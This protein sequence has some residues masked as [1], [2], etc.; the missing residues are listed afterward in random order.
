MTRST[1]ILIARCMGLVA[2]FYGVSFGLA[3]AAM[4]RPLMTSFTGLT[5]RV[6]LVLLAGALAYYLVRLAY[7]IW[8]RFS[9]SVI[10]GAL[11]VAAFVLLLGIRGIL[12]FNAVPKLVSSITLLGSVPALCGLHR[13]ATTPNLFGCCRVTNPPG[14]LT[15][16]PAVIQLEGRH[17][18]FDLNR[19]RQ[20]F[21]AHAFRSG[22]V[23]AMNSRSII[24]IIGTCLALVSSAAEQSQLSLKSGDRTVLSYNVT[25][26]PSPI[27]GA[28][29]YGRSGFIHPLF[30]PAGRM[31]TEAFPADHP[32]Q[33]GLMFAW[34]TATF[35]GRKLNFWDQKK[36]EGII[37]HARTIHADDRRIVVELRHVDITNATPK[38][39]LSETW[40]L[41]HVPH[42]TMNVIDLVST[43]NCA[44]QS[45]VTLRKYHYGGMAVRGAENWMAEGADM[46]TD[47]GKDRQAGN[48]TR[49]RWVTMAGKVDGA[50][51][52]I[53]AMCHPENFRAPQSVR[54]HPNK[55]YFCF[56]PMVLGEFKIKPGSPYVS[57]YRIIAFDGE[58]DP[59]KLEA[60]WRQYTGG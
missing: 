11:G 8:F 59:K 52:G 35:E 44:T 30:T 31:V 6:P 39:A 17:L 19:A 27:S 57:R 23:R 26:Q 56:A 58:P 53:V 10:P 7:R 16:P 9:P 47:E 20:G 18:I 14:R 1:I 60:L 40:E 12:D 4:L 25:H 45:P 37:E 43:Q 55:P 32:H 28:A 51:C 2:A 49:P 5:G 15:K 36:Q 22:I 41:T 46:R 42:P 50:D 21:I 33:H 48:H 54:L 38:T 13:H 24:V 34:T 29:Y 3:A